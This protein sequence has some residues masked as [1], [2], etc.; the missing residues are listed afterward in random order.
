[1]LLRSQVYWICLRAPHLRQRVGFRP[2]GGAMAGDGRIE[3]EQRAVGIEHAELGARGL[4]ALLGHVLGYR[5]FIAIVQI[6][7]AMQ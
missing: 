3:V 6:P 5:M 2:D 4:I 7:G 1:M